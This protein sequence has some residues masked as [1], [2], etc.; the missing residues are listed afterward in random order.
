MGRTALGNGIY[1]TCFKVF[2]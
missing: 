2:F 1:I